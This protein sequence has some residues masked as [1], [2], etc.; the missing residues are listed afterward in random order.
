MLT[1]SFRPA[2]SFRREVMSLIA[3]DPS[4]LRVDFAGQNLRLPRP[5]AGGPLLARLPD[6][7][8]WMGLPRTDQSGVSAAFSE[9]GAVTFR[10]TDLAD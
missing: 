3:K 7:V 5:L 10:V 9:S 1:M 6:D 8:S 4:P 2:P